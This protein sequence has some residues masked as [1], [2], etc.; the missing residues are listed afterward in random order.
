MYEQC[1]I[2]DRFI[3][4]ESELLDQEDAYEIDGNILCEDCVDEYVKKNCYKK[5]KDEELPFQEVSNDYGTH[6]ECYPNYKE[7]K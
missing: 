7:E 5:L 2:C 1:Y 4:G 6:K 3:R